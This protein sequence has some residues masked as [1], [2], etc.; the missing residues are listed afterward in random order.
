MSRLLILLLLLS[1]CRSLHQPTRPDYSQGV[2]WDL[3]EAEP[4]NYLAPERRVQALPTILVW[5]NTLTGCV[6][7]Q[8]AYIYEHKR[9]RGQ[10]LRIPY[11]SAKK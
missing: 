9:F 3:N 10:F 11:Q 7:Y 1:A 6:Y 5:S 2:G 8:T 4:P